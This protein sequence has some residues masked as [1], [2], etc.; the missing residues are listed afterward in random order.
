MYL[1]F[2]AMHS[3]GRLPPYTPYGPS[4][5]SR[6]NAFLRSQKN[7]NSRPSGD[8]HF[9]KTEGAN[10]EVLQSECDVPKFTGASQ[11]VDEQFED[12]GEG[13]MFCDGDRSG[14][15]REKKESSDSS[16]F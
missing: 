8:V 16:I 7:S 4:F 6:F 14:S 9:Q 12:K 13:S 5:A 15:K 3:N 2:A 11:F 10:S 1:S